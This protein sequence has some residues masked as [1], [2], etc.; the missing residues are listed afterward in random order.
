MEQQ[1]QAVVHTI[2]EIWPI[3]TLLFCAFFEVSKIPISPFS[4]LRDW[5]LKPATKRMDEIVRQF[6]MEVAELK[7]LLDK[8]EKRA[9]I[10]KAKRCRGEVLSF[11]N[12]CKN[13]AKHT[14]DEFLHIIDA[15]KTYEKLCEL[16]PEI[17]NGIVEAEYKYI[18][19]VYYEC[20]RE[21]KFL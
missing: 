6:E 19:D 12:S 8:C 13:D 14:K 3:L 9:N 10:D 2:K 11:A 5:L 7:D 16:Y 20:Q 15:H 21:N 1:L 18:M 17:E 4:T